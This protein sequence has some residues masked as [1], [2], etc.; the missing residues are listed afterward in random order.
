MTS[1]PGAWLC[2]VVVAGF[3]AGLFAV[4]V[5]ASACRFL[6]ACLAG[7]GQGAQWLETRVFWGFARCTALNGSLH[8]RF[9]LEC[10]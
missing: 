9:W 10:G 3:A 6:A 4:I 5:V 1:T 8:R 2:T 7:I